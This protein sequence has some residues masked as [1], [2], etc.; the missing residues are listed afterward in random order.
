MIGL[1]VVAAHLVGDYLLQGDA[2]AARK[3]RCGWTRAWHVTVYTLPFFGVALLNGHGWARVF[4]FLL[5]VWVTHFLTDSVRWQLGSSWP[6]KALM[7]DQAIHLA[8]LALLVR[9]LA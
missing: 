2:M 4:L 1:D 9:V 5:L 7:V 8:T 6:Q 3:L